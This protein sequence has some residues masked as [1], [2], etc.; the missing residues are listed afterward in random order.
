MH[1]FQKFATFNVGMFEEKHPRSFCRNGQPSNHFSGIDCPAG[2]FIDGSEIPGVAPPNGRIPERRGA[3][4]FIHSGQ[5]HVPIDP[6]FGENF[7]V[8]GQDITEAGKISRSGFG[9]SQTAGVA[10]GS[11]SK[12]FCF[13]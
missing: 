12:R 3:S 8:P 6:Q 10:A 13:Q 2:N 1:R 9:E 7:L 5:T 4:Q 11:G